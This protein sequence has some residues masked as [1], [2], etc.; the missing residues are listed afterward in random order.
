MTQDAQKRMKRNVLLLFLCQALSQMGM[1]GQVSMAAL[2]GAS[3]ASNKALAT[4]PI[5]MQ[6]MA[7]MA[8]SIPGAYIMRYLGR[9]T[10]FLIGSGL[11][12]VGAVLFVVALQRH[13]FALF[14]IAGSIAGLY[15][16]LAQNYRFAAAE[17]AGPE[18]R[19]RAIALVMAG[20]VVSAILGPEMVKWTKELWLPVLFAGT[21]L[22]TAVLPLIATFLITLT[23]LPPPLPARAGTGRPLGAIVRQPAFIVAAASGMFGWGAMNLIMASTPVEMVLCGFS[24]DTAATVIQAHALGMYV[25]SFFS[26][27][28]IARYGVLRVIG[29]GALLSMLTTVICIYNR[30]FVNFWGG[31]SLLGLGWNFMY[32]GGTTL[33]GRAHSA[34][35]RNKAQAANDFL[36]FGTVTITAFS[37]GAIHHTLGWEALNLI[38]LPALALVLGLLVWFAR[39][40]VPEPSL[41][42]A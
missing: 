31:L 8:V 17:I 18:F 24:I 5:A 15:F 33:L 6:M 35:E 4:L 23:D 13:D 29:T 10:G 42:A 1:V 3:L 7:S 11:G 34:E 2:V 41:R 40:P 21:Y 26:G 25:P 9:R 37:S 14:C 12:F 32:V 27:R 28:L 22:A 19:P 39:Q 20:G 16:G 38:V 30:G 36:V